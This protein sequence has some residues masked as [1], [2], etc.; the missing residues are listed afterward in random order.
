[1]TG[2]GTVD[3]VPGR[4]THAKTDWKRLERA[5]LEADREEY[6]QSTPGQRVEAQIK[7]SRELTAL[8]SRR[9]RH[10]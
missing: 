5:S 8:A 7:L 2:S 3:D 10:S 1:M 4:T 9:T 6:R